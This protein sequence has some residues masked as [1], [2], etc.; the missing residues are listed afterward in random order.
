MLQKSIFKEI[1]TLH[2]IQH[3][4]KLESMI[5]KALTYLTILAITALPVQLIS[6]SAEIVGMQMSMSQPVLE[7][8]ECSSDMGMQHTNLDSQQD[9]M[10]KSCCDDQSHN[11]QSCNNCPQAVSVIFLP[12]DTFVKISSLEIQKYSTSYLFLNGVPQKNLLRPPR[13]LI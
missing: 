7:N 2:E 11:C 5:R 4:I 10:D 3:S 8:S 9:S 1:C 12:L 6:A 13:I